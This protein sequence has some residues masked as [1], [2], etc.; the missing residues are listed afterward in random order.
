MDL[1]PDE[2][3]LEP[4]EAETAGKPAEPINVEELVRKA[5]RSRQIAE[6]D[7]QSILATASEV[8]ADRLYERL[9]KLNIRIVSADGEAVD[10]PGE[11]GLLDNLDEI[12]TESEDLYLGD[13]EDDPVHTYLKEIGQVPRFICRTGNLAG[14]ANAGGACTG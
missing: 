1:E 5:R 13:A 4:D 9:Q 2:L 7:V 10:D 12:E 3:D 6:S 14:D 11:I 8:E